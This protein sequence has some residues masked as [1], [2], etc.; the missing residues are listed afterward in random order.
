[1]R[2]GAAAVV[3]VLAVVGL[4]ILVVGVGRMFSVPERVGREMIGWTG[5]PDGAAAPGVGGRVSGMQVERR[6][7]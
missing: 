4:S 6:C 5:A 2:A 7:M 1:M 3:S